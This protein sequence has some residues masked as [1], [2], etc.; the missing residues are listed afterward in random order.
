[1]KRHNPI[2]ILKSYESIYSHAVEVP[3]S[4]RILYISGQVGVGEEGVTVSGGFENQCAQAI[5]NIEK[6]LVSAQMSL[7]NIVKVTIFITQGEHLALLR[8]V[9]TD[10]LAVAPA[11]TTVIVAGLHDPSWLV[12]IDATAAAIP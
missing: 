7:I 1:M 11:V 8:K 6:V 2:P 3:A 5:L 10:R 12:E 4:S 9:R